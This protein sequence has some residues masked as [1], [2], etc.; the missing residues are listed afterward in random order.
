MFSHVTHKEKLSTVHKLCSASEN[1]IVYITFWIVGTFSHLDIW[2]E[3]RPISLFFFIPTTIGFCMGGPSFS[4]LTKKAGCLIP[5]ARAGGLNHVSHSVNIQRVNTI[6]W[7]R[8]ICGRCCNF[9]PT[10]PPTSQMTISGSTPESREKSHTHDH[11][12]S[13]QWRLSV[14]YL[15]IENENGDRGSDTSFNFAGVS[16]G[17]N[18]VIL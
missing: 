17:S 8:P 13:S 16:P 9:R 12:S 2:L 6:K 14:I 18:L 4:L 3:P 5:C 10:P 7:A 1:P 15:Q 11:A